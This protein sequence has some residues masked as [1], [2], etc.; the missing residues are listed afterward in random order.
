M[1]QGR[2]FPFAAWRPKVDVKG[3]P[4][5]TQGGFYGH[6]F[7]ADFIDTQSNLRASELK[8]HDANITAY[9]GYYHGKLTKVALTNQHLWQK[10]PDSTRPSKMVNSDLGLPDEDG[11]GK[12]QKLT[13]PFGDSQTNITWAALHWTNASHGKPELVKN[14]TE[15]VAVANGGDELKKYSQLK[16]CSRRGD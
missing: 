14:T 11:K 8:T 4:P 6:K 9:V 10:K 7:V 15:R 1:Q 2:N 16:H 12:M 5:H 13:A 3:K